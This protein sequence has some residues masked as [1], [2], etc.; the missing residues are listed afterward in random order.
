MNSLRS[1]KLGIVRTPKDGN[2]LFAALSISL[3]SLCQWE[4]VEEE[5]TP[6]TLRS[7]VCDVLLERSEEFSPFFTPSSDPDNRAALDLEDTQDATYED[8]VRRMRAD[9]EWGGEF[10]LMA[11]AV[12][13]GRPV[14]VYTEDG[15]RSVRGGGD[16]LPPVCVWYVDES[17]YEAVVYEEKAR[18]KTGN[19]KCEGCGKKVKKCKC[20]DDDGFSKVRI[21]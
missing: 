7:A 16:D 3:D 15:S 12:I 18:R 11:A 20:V 6:S 1:E 10:E 8:Y 4:D 14:A 13:L 21:K 19:D 5:F 2:C 9:G 17:H